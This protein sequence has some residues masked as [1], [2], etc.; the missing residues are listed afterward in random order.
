MKLLKSIP[1]L[2]WVVVAILLGILLGPVMPVWLGSVFLTY[3][4]IFS[5]F[6]GFVV[7]LI[8]FGLVAP[9]IAELGKGAGKWLGITAA[10][11]YASTLC[12][13]LL[14]YFVSRWLFTKSLSG[15]GVEEVGGGEGS[16]FEPY[17]SL[18]GSAGESATEI[19]LEPLMGVMTALVL[20]FM[21]GLGLT[22]FRSTVIFRGAV[23]FRN[24]IEMV[25]R[26]VVVPALPLFI[27]GIFLDLSAAGDAVTVVQKFLFVAVVSF[28]LTLVVLL[29]QY[30]IAG[31]MNKRNPL[32]A[33]WGMR[34]AYFTALGT[35]S[36]AATIPVT[37]ESAKKN[38]VSD[39][40]AGFVIPLC[41]TI[42][43][44]GSMVKITCFSIAVLLL[45]GG[46]V[47]FGAYFPFI[48]MLGVMMVAAPGVPGGAI[49]AAAGLLAQMLG[50]GEVEVGLMFAAYIALDSFGTATNVTGDGALAMIMHKLTRGKLGA[51]PQDPED[52]VV[53]LADGTEAADHK[54][55]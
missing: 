33:L 38:G 6:L 1:L 52:E 15:G 46:D 13:G 36:S 12:A 22:A 29:V 4:S 21:L 7:P 9:A 28:V 25:I 42:H 24:I 27:F 47:S 34:N 5:G 14:A 26:R 20:A 49:A 31:A 50:F 53:E 37:L 39:A 18:V 51:Q 19:V 30:S 3:N 11:A 16:G 43:L 41:A 44:S 54:L 17:F 10:I 2:G 40:V 8:I 45:T 48:L 35:S 32:A 23:E 55:A